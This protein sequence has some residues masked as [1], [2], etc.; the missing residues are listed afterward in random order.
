MALKA[1]YHGKTY[2]VSVHEENMFFEVEVLQVL[3]KMYED[4]ANKEPVEEIAYGFHAMLASY[5]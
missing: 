2:P 5:G 3:T 1:R 4:W